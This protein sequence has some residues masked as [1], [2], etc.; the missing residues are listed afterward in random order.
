VD[1]GRTGAELFGTHELLESMHDNSAQHSAH[2]HANGDE[3][4]HAAT[5]IYCVNLFSPPSMVSIRV[6][7]TFTWRLPPTFKQASSTNTCKQ[8]KEV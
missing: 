5:Q 6:V 1:T 8:A 4:G 2:Q 3:S 7:D